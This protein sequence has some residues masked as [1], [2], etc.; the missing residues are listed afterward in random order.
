[1]PSSPSVVTAMTSSAS[2]EK[3]TSLGE[4]S[5]NGIAFAMAGLRR[6][7]HL[8]GGFLH[9]V[10]RAGVE[11][12]GFGQV[13]DFAVEDLLERGDRLGKLDVLSRTARELLG[14]EER[15]R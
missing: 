6:R 2:P 1:M 14:N 3:T 5:L 4:M 12:C 11:E 15:L 9:F 13:V 10:D 7:A 8:F